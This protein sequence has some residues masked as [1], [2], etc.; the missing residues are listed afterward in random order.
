[1]ATGKEISVLEG[2]GGAV[3]SLAISADG[4]TIVSGSYDNYDNTIR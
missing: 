1:M 3:S 2:H 4:K